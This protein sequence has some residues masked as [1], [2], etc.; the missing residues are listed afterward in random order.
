MS[1]VLEVLPTGPKA[2]TLLLDGMPGGVVEVR[3]SL[4]EAAGE[5]GPMSVNLSNCLICGLAVEKSAQAEHL[6]TVHPSPEGGFP[7]FLDGRLCHS[8][9]PSMLVVDVKS[10]YGSTTTYHLYQQLSPDE[11]VFLSDGQAV[12]L[13]Q[14]PHFFAI[15]PARG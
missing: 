14:C 2:S 13:T 3:A 1:L 15:P 10:R 11:D 12:D 9:E 8:D 5:G 7:F 4:G 6:R